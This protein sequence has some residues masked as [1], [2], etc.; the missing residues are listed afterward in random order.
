L[1]PVPHVPAVLVVDA[2]PEVLDTVVASLK[3]QGYRLRTTTSIERGLRHLR[4]GTFDCVLVDEDLEQTSGG[5]LQGELSRYPP[6]TVSLIILSR[7]PYGAR[8]RALRRGAYDCVARPFETDVLRITVARAIERTSLARGMRELLDE[9]DAANAELRSSREQLQ[10]RVEE[11]TRD[12][13]LK[14]DE[15]DRARRELET[16]RRQRDEFIHVIAHELGG[17]LTAVEGYAELL[18]ERTVPHEAQRRA[19]KVIRGETR[20]IARLV[21]D[22]ASSTDLTHELTLEVGSCDLVEL[23]TEQV[24]LASGLGPGHVVLDDVHPTALQARCD[25]VR[26]GQVVFNLLSN[27]MKYSNGR[28]IRVRLRGHDGVA[29]VLVID[30]GMGIP[31]DRLEAIFEPHVRLIQPAAS[32]PSGSGLG[33]YVARRIAEAHGGSLRAESSGSGAT[34]VLRLP[35]AEPPR[36]LQWRAAR[37]A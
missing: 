11:A 24:E 4:T 32:Q 35:L 37:S 16:A 36:V 17:P 19:A 8:L 2:D 31:A 25:R 13:R 26:V 30:R 29:E 9:L 3:H 1:H 23:V 34:F 20:R 33:L 12:L 18:R 27:A 28:D 7:R 14:L 22:L 15:L 21:Q 6:E 5:R 10:R